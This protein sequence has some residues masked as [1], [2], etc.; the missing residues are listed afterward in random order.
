MTYLFSSNTVITNEVEIKNE[1]GNAISTQV[2]SNNSFVSSSNPFPVSITSATGPD[3]NFEFTSK[4]RLK[5][6]T[7]ET[8]F[9]NTFQYGKETDVW[10][11]ALTNG[12]SAT[13]NANTS[14]ILMAVSN[15]VGSQVIRQTHNVQKYMPGRTSTLNFV[16]RMQ[17]PVVGVRRRFG[18]FDT[19]DGAYFED[20]GNN[21]Y[22]CAIRSSFTGVP[23]D[24]RVER[25]NWN[26]DRLDGTGP[27]GITANPDALQMFGIEYEWY[28]AGSVKFTYN[29]AGKTYT[30]HTFNAANILNNPW[31][32]TPFL[33]IRLELT[34]VTG[35]AG[36]H[37]MWQGSNSLLSEGA[38]EKRGSPQNKMSPIGGTTLTTKDIFYPLLSIKMKPSTL[39]GII[40]P[41]FAQVA[42]IDNTSLYYRIVRNATLTGSSFTDMPD[43]NAFTQYDTTATALSGGVDIESGFL[44]GFGA[45]G[46]I[47]LDKDT[48]YQLGR[49]GMGTVSDTITIAIAS[50]LANKSGLATMTWIEQ[51]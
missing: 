22:F 39:R 1:T 31:S 42:T 29:I 51:R 12:G 19:E 2:F 10:D 3:A 48:S 32:T 18:L 40:L 4:N 23:I 25:A 26:G 34:N 38:P 36:S 50:T 13:F 41:T 11:E 44:M 20:A 6:S 37:Y 5:I 28:G 17:I 43:P 33:P 47:V 45:V 7:F 24:T 9:Y 46:R 14:S 16:I 15:T 27:S 8:I 21:T 49:T 30:I 35:A